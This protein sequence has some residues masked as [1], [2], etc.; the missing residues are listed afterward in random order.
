M[1]KPTSYSVIPLKTSPAKPVAFNGNSAQTAIRP[2]IIPMDKVMLVGQSTECEVDLKPIR[3]AG[4]DT[5]VIVCMPDGAHRGRNVALSEA[6]SDL[7][8]CFDCLKT[9]YL[10]SVNVCIMVS[11]AVYAGLDGGLITF[12]RSSMPTDHF[13]LQYNVSP[14]LS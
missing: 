1:A 4:S 11:V 9:V 5:A 8:V 14:S 10:C 13:L 12:V 3:H 6:E 7:V 2:K